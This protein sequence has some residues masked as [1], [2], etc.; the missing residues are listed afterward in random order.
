MVT[1]LIARHR[2]LMRELKVELKAIKKTSKTPDDEDQ[3][4]NLMRAARSPLRRLAEKS[5]RKKGYSPEKQ[6]SQEDV[7]SSLMEAEEKL[8]GN[9]Y[10]MPWD[11]GAGQHG[12]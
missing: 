11:T 9:V 12:H 1:S 4:E 7:V 5:L 2:Q 10:V 6:A 8:G 3:G